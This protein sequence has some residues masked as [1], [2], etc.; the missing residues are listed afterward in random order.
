MERSGSK[1]FVR[2]C[3]L[4]LAVALLCAF[5]IAA[6]AAENGTDN[7]PV[8]Y[9]H[10][11]VNG[12]GI[13]DNR[14]AIYTLYHFVY[15]D[16]QYPVE[17]DWDFNG[18]GEHSN[19]DAIYVL[20]ASLFEDDPD[21]QLKGLVHSYYDPAWEWSEE[22]GQVTAQ[23]EFKCG[24]GEDH[25][26]STEEGGVTVVSSVKEAAT[27][28]KNGTLEYVASV[29]FDGQEYTNTKTESI[30]VLKHDMDGFQ[31]CEDGAKCKNCDYELPALGHNWEEKSRTEAS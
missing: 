29:E 5:S 6:L 25:L 10:G 19:K 3:T 18:D 22:D 1:H 13:I 2:L 30:P 14:D 7:E 20:Y 26:F 24:C 28:L 27:C 12:D 11:D 15:G 23:V 31:T 21:Y 9:T 4:L 17:Q 16:E 8:C